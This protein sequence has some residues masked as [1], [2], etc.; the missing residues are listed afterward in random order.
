MPQEQMVTPEHQVTAENEPVAEF[1]KDAA[2]VF[3]NDEVVEYVD[4]QDKVVEAPDM[5]ESTVDL[6]S[7]SVVSLD[8]ENANKS[9]EDAVFKDDEEIVFE[10]KEKS[11]WKPPDSE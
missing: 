10:R 9:T 6:N 4:V 5:K 1:R 11:I 7:A 8:D 2:P 3:G